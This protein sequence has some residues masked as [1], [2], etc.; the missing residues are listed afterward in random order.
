[1]KERETEKSPWGKLG[2]MEQDV[3]V[4]VEVGREKGGIKYE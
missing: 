2:K 1:M 4:Q 3:T